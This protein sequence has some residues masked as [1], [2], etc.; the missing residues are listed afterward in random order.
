MILNLNQRCHLLEVNWDF[1]PGCLA[2]TLTLLAIVPPHRHGVLPLQ[3]PR[4]KGFKTQGIGKCF[5]VEVYV[6]GLPK[7]KS[8][9]YVPPRPPKNTSPI[10]TQV[11]PLQ[12]PNSCKVLIETI[13]KSFGGKTKNKKLPYLR[14]LFRL[15]LRQISWV[16]L[17]LEFSFF[18]RKELPGSHVRKKKSHSVY[19]TLPHHTIAN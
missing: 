12:T 16:C 15:G 5:C 1:Y 10:F 19:V 6:F 8:K 17:R 4:H 18:Q 11:L 2:C 14:G 7:V 3:A 9:L 13:L